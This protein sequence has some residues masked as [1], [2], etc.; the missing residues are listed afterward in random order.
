MAQGDGSCYIMISGK[1]NPNDEDFSNRVASK[2]KTILRVS[3]E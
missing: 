1:G 2:L 3:L